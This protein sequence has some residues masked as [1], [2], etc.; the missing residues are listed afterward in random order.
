AVLVA[1][2]AAA[3]LA[4]A[5]VARRM[6][7]GLVDCAA[8]GPGAVAVLL[9]CLALLAGSGVLDDWYLNTVTALVRHAHNRLDVDPLRGGLM[10]PVAL[11]LAGDVALLFVANLPALWR[12]GSVRRRSAVA[13]AV[14]GLAALHC[15]VPSLVAR[16]TVVKTLYLDAGPFELFVAL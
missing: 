11:G 8:L 7:D 1:S 3:L 2:A 15:A 6:R 13:V 9:A 14:L 10:L 5:V 16:A 12:G 4:N